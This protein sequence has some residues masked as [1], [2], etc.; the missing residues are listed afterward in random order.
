MAEDNLRIEFHLTPNGW[1]RGTTR[2]FDKVQNVIVE[3]PSNAV[4]TSELHIFQRSSWSPEQRTW[5]VLWRLDGISDQ[6]LKALYRKF[7][8]PD[9]N[10]RN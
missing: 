6:E 5:K 9:E 8:Q 3:R 4:E 10:F 7:P 2:Y 1:L